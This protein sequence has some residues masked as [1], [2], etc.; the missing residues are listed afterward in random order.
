MF[1]RGSQ[2]N[3]PVAGVASWAFLCVLTGTMVTTHTEPRASACLSLGSPASQ[4][5]HLPQGQGLATE[6]ADVGWAL[7]VPQAQ[8]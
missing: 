7:H 6:M 2:V 8:C 1:L 5:E 3:P 4:T